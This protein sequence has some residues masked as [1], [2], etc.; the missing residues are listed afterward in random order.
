MKEKIDKEPEAQDEP[1]SWDWIYLVLPLAGIVGFAFGMALLPLG[2]VLGF[3]AL[4]FIVGF[5][6]SLINP[7]H[8]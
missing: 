4:A 3:L 5:F 8:P 2:W 6:I 7:H 1:K